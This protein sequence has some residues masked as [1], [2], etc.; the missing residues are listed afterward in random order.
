MTTD[1]K[2]EYKIYDFLIQKEPLD[3]DTIGGNM[4][5]RYLNDLIIFARKNSLI[6]YNHK[7][8]TTLKSIDL[9]QEIKCISIKKDRVV[10]GT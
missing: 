5:K 4:V 9:G 2:P 8:H 3:S 10:V 7:E 6:F 1:S